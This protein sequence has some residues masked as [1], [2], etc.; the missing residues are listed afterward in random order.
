MTPTGADKGHAVRR[1]AAALGVPLGEVAV[2]GD[3]GNDMP[4][5]DVAPFRIAMGNATDALKAKATYVTRDNEHDGFAAAVEG[6]IL[7]R[8][9]G[10]TRQPGAKD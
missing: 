10:S 4:M 3:M 6:Y 5:F 9:A 1:I 8:A 2:I 7:P